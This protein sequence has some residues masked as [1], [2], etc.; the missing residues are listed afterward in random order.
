[1]L[2][3]IGIDVSDYEKSKAFYKKTL[4]PLGYQLIMEIMSHAGFVLMESPT[5]GSAKER[6]LPH[7]YM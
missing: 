4:A 3:H 1:M 7:Q 6:R 5:S 2:D